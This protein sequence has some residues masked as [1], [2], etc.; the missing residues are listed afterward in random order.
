VIDRTIVRCLGCALGWIIA[1]GHANAAERAADRILRGS[2]DASANHSYRLL[3]FEVPAGVAGLEIRFAYSG[4]ESR[5]TI[6]LGLLAPGEDFAQAFRG[7]SGGNKSAFM[8]GASDA[9]PSYLAGPIAPGTWRLLIGVP[10]IRA[11][12]TSSYVAEIFFR[13]PGSQLPTAS[14]VIASK[15]GP[16]WYRGDLHLH[17]GHSDGNCASRSGRARV[18]CPTFLTLTAASE[19]GLDF[20]ALTE[21]NT[22]SQ[23]R[24]ITALQPYFD[25]LLLIPGT[26]LTTF[27]GHANAL[28]IDAP[29]DFR[30]GSDEVP[31]WNALLR[32]PAL[33]GALV[34]INHPNLPS[35][36]ICMG[37]GWTAKPRVDWSKLQ[38]IE[39]VNGHFAEGPYSGTSFWHQRLQEGHR[40]TAIGGSDAHD[41]SATATEGSLPP[42]RVGVP[43]TVVYAR[44]LSQADILEGLR[45]G[46]VFVD[47]SGTR[48]RSV[49]LSA[50]ADD[51]A[52]TM[53]GEI[54]LARGERAAVTVRGRNL[55][56]GRL[57]IVR[58]G[59]VI[60]RV[61]IDA[62]E[63]THSF[64]EHGDGAPHWVRVDVRDA[65]GKLALIGNPIYINRSSAAAGA[66]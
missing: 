20:V 18:P 3:P 65:G 17:S 10:N 62:Q 23:L 27:Q 30:V 59:G 6:D 2:I 11:G 44:S 52:A 13:R 42:A 1:I 14:D 4:R 56:G 5:T 15:N 49:E 21:H 47:V 46:N 29:V 61:E 58:D 50:Q 38:A 40:L 60:S 64:D 39:V 55:E 19:R 53:G 31:D 66:P 34:S 33:G 45:A 36:E 9:T 12:Q 25:D 57:E 43:A 16:G 37:C 41:V 28:G 22:I 7:W 48:D 32:S 54:V 51:R 35:G 26:E 8:L 63:F 24:E